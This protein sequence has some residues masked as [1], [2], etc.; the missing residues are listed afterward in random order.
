MLLLLL[1]G[2]VQDPNSS[3]VGWQKE[4]DAVT[5]SSEVLS[6]LSS[7][8]EATRCLS[9][10]LAGWLP[11][12]LLVLHFFL[13]T[14]KSWSSLRHFLCSERGGSA[15][16][17]VSPEPGDSDAW[18]QRWV[19]CP[20]PLPCAP[21]TWLCLPQDLSFMMQIHRGCMWISTPPPSHNF[22]HFCAPLSEQDC[23]A[24]LPLGLTPPLAPTV[25]TQLAGMSVADVSNHSQKPGIYLL[26]FDFKRSQVPFPNY[27][28]LRFQRQGADHMCN[29]PALFTACNLWCGFCSRCQGVTFQR[30]LN[31]KHWVPLGEQAVFF[32]P[33]DITRES[34]PLLTQLPSF[35]GG[36]GKLL[37]VNSHC[38]GT[39]SQMRNM[40]NISAT[41]SPLVQAWRDTNR[42]ESNSS[43]FVNICKYC[44]ISL[45]YC[46]S[47][48]FCFP[49]IPA[50]SWTLP[51][52]SSWHLS[53][54]HWSAIHY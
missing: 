28:A 38:S 7:H 4:R 44:F 23:G 6:W 26:H 27:S 43:L 17:A 20:L 40:E 46:K 11:D 10:S 41:E 48:N 21:I 16:R 33:E 5:A 47:L 39:R 54:S 52:V 50:L 35:R 1:L 2:S 22:T 36:R 29:N 53:R 12:L 31:S 49:R 8:T 13:K 32:T 24:G 19:C 3:C 14:E 51:L 42:I 30:E 37:S 34:Q 25:S 15:A 9:I 45:G 18:K